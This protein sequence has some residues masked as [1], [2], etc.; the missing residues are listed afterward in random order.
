MPDLAQSLSKYDIGFL[1]I[2]AQFWDLD[3]QL[4]DKKEAVFNLAQLM[5]QPAIIQPFFQELPEEAKAA[6][7]ELLSQ[8]G[9]IPYSLFSRKYG[10]IRQVGTA[11]RDREMLYLSPISTLEFLWYRGL[12]FRDFFEQNGNI[13]EMVYIPSDFLD[14]LPIAGG[15]EANQFMGYAL[16]NDYAQ[17]F[18]SREFILEDVC[19][20]LAWLR[21]NPADSLS[22]LEPFITFGFYSH[23]F[24]PSNLAIHFLF[25]MLI[26]ANLVQEDGAPQVNAIKDLLSESDGRAINHLIL[27]WFSSTTINELKSLPELICSGD[28]HNDPITTRQFLIQKIQTIHYHR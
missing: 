11:K 13:E 24:L 5:L 6:L 8:Q 20:L 26:S 16:P 21:K 25:Q 14:A 18:S 28:W 19:T 17:Q 15:I 27:S 23:P 9:Q 2:I 3:L 12:I 4:Q 10:E 22:V 1:H 7:R